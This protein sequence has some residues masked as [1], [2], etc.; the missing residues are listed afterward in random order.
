MSKIDKA[1]KDTNMA[2]CKNIKR[3]DDSERGLLCQNILSQLRNFVEYIITKIVNYPKDVDPNNYDIKQKAIAKIRAMGQ[4]RFI[5]NFYDLLQKSVSHYTVDEDGSER[6]MLKY[7]EYL[8][9]IK[10]LLKNK[11][12]LDVL[13]NIEDFPLNNDKH[14]QEY[15]EKISEKINATAGEKCKYDDRC[16][17]QK[18]KPFFVNNRIFYEIT[19]TI[20]NDNISKFDRQIAFTE[21]EI[22]DNYA[23]K[24]SLRNDTI[25][26]K[27][28]DLPIQIIDS[29]QISIRQCELEKIAYILGEESN[30]NSSHKEYISL[31][32]FLTYNK[33][34]LL[35][36]V[37][38]PMEDYDK[39]KE[40]LLIK[41]KVNSIFN[42]LDKCRFIILQNAT[43][44][45]TLRYLL[46]KLNNKILREQLAI[47]KCE[48]L[49]DLN[50]KYGCLVFEKMPFASSLI[51][52]NP[53]LRDLL[54]CIDDKV[55][56]YEFFARK[57]KNNTEQHDILFTSAKELD[58]FGDVD[59]LMAKYNAN[60]Y[61]KHQGRKIKK[62]KN[63]F[64]IDE[65][66]DDSAYIIKK[67][68]ELTK[69]HI[70][71]YRA[72]V[73]SW[74]REYAIDSAEKIDALEKMFDNSLVAMIYGSAGTGKSTLI[75][76][77][78]NF[79]SDKDKLFLANTHPAVENMHRKV[80][81]A[82]C[83]FSTISSFL[84]KNNCECDVLVIDECSTISNRDMRKILEKAKFKLLIL[85]GD[86]YQ[87]ES[88][89]FGN[90]FSIA[91]EFIPQKAI[92]ELKNPYRTR[93]KDLLNVWDKVRNLDIAI[94]EPLVKNKYSQ[95]LDESL[96]EKDQKDEVILCLNYD[97][98]YGI[99]N[100]NRFL[101]GRN[102]N[103]SVEWGVLTYKI[104]DRVLFNE[105]KRF[106]PLIY[107]NMKGEIVNIV[108][109]E[110]KIWFEIELE[111]AINELDASGYSFKLLG[112][113]KSNNSII[114]FWVEK[115]KNTDDD[116]D[117]F[118]TLVP[119][120][121]AYAI[122]IHKA[123]GLEYESVKIVVVNEVAELITHNIFY[124]AITRAKEKLKIYW[125]PETE[126]KILKSLKKKESHRDYELLKVLYSLDCSQNI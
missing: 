14:F 123:Q 56:D 16:Y 28:Q 38:L 59:S 75:N 113:S 61:Y 60:V 76:H 91:K 57:I 90:W 36:L 30:I 58:K 22:I 126:Y 9:R 116:S 53:K 17:V 45:N 44:C 89:M 86:I 66:A 40:Q 52:H 51:N 67:L 125:T 18:I 31:M 29:W 6:L 85:V 70:N 95:S 100:I 117:S 15:Y 46:Y 5:N 34:S 13:E 33:L 122:S 63:H 93:D 104:G 121:V 32:N 74:L 99:N 71:G 65:Y 62:F 25:N 35:D 102:P 87:I 88:I 78:S 103:P 111:I 92:I 114:G 72:S 7:Y 80:K 24:L 124:T 107:N 47:E 8:L 64:Y 120:Q 108:V 115:Y 20:A 112:L 79:L 110:S 119:F 83:K 97:G 50:L 69:E 77:I 49:S 3:F 73:K 37:L 21:H 105:S 81:A 43:G 96:F 12:A 26:I 54:S 11:Y 27:G 48:N 109:E 42:I 10:D 39:I 94:L 84:A 19:F 106:S 118:A 23:M 4:Y 68:Y 41:T 101:Q 55:R 82:N 2:I 98:L 1:I